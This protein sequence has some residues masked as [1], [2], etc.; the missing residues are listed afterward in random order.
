M[1]YAWFWECVAARMADAAGYPA[2]TC[3]LFTPFHTARP[4]VLHP[5]QPRGAMAA[6]EDAL[7]APWPPLRTYSA[8]S[9]GLF[10]AWQVPAGHGAGAAHHPGGEGRPLQ[11]HHAR[12][13]VHHPR[14][15]SLAPATDHVCSP[16]RL[17]SLCHY[18]QSSHVTGPL[19]SLPAL[20]RP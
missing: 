14:R 18:V 7:T 8:S 4:H 1:A 17:L 3:F 16:S 9:E 2:R 13:P 11:R 12:H 20:V 15:A 10:E 19:C 6:T 5:S